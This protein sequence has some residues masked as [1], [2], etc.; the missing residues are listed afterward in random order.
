VVPEQIA[1]TKRSGVPGMFK[2]LP[3]VTLVIM[4]LLFSVSPC[5]ANES[6]AGYPS[7][8]TSGYNMDKGMG[9][10]PG[11]PSVPVESP[12]ANQTP[13][14]QPPAQT[15]APQPAPQPT[16]TKPDPQPVPQPAP[17]PVS[18]QPGEGANQQG[19]PTS[20]PGDDLNFEWSDQ[21]GAQDSL[22]QDPDTMQ[23]P[24]LQ[25]D[26]TESG[27]VENQQGSPSPGPG[28]DLDFEWSDQ[29][30]TPGPFPQ[31]SEMMLSPPGVPMSEE[32]DYL[33]PTQDS[34]GSS[35]YKD[36]PWWVEPTIET[37]MDA[38]DYAP[39]NNAKAIYNTFDHLLNGEPIQAVQEIASIPLGWVG[40]FIGH[41]QKAAGLELSM[42][43]L[44]KWLGEP[45]K[46]QEPVKPPEKRQDD[47]NWWLT[48]EQPLQ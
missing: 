24:D 14:Q 36:L 5:Q 25:P 34:R 15:P 16:P 37:I 29:E 26:P 27:E 30:H 48:E 23:P 35:E 2:V 40:T 39:T 7:Y 31:D 44:E 12:P 9:W 1:I 21:K 41:A 3:V 20:G 38:M 42:G 4:F 11:G 10:K 17:Q 45:P 22:P 47:P 8:D 28:D 32:A 43:N 46:P 19:P 18:P 13:V 6:Q 33:D